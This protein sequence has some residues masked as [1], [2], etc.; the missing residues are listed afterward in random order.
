MQ[1]IQR[2]TL[3]VACVATA[4][5]MLDIAVVNTAMSDI[6]ADL[7]A[8][9]TELQWI[10]DAYTLALA[11]AVLAGGAL[12][13]RL[14]RRKVFVAGLVV[15][16]LASGVCAAATQVVVLDAARAVQGLGGALMFATSLALIAEAFPGR[17][18]RQKALGAYGA[19]VAASLAIGPLVGGALTSALDWRWIF[20]VNLPVGALALVACLR[21]V[22]E[23]ADPQAPRADIAGQSV[24]AAGLLALVLGLLQAPDRGFE[25]PLVVL[26]LGFGAAL[27]V[28]FVVIEQHVAHPVLPLHL[29]RDRAFAGAHIAAFALSASL[30]AI[31]LYI[32]LYL[33][34]VLGLSAVEA[35]LVYVPG[36]AVMFVVALLS[37]RVAE[38]LPAP[39]AVGGGLL[40]VAVGMALCTGLAATSSWTVLLPGMLLAMVGTGMLNPALV[41]LAIGAVPDR[42]AGLA[43]GSV[44]TFRQ[45]GIAVGVAALGALAPTDALLAGD[46][47]AYVEGLRDA[48]WFGAG[49]AGAGALAA[50]VL[51][52]VRSGARVP[53]RIAAQRA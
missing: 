40:L 37:H 49:I 17:A 41:A 30:F 29:F 35:G 7:R 2:K 52:G 13:D 14:G 3:A 25:D 48:V 39:V 19:T 4:M 5:L 32:T 22:R 8:G 45:A 21:W 31:Y 38:R 47:V 23:S 11:A 51:L 34:Q 36:T 53:A 28:C 15:F 10:V 20:L 1:A 43:S 46:G 6:A 42:Q 50:F 16:T 27:V 18:E 12:A 9:V 33:Q 24:L 44:A 26:A